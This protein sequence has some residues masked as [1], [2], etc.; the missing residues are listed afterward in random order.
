MPHAIHLFLEQVSH[1]L[2]DN[3]WFY[4]NGPHVLQAG[5]QA[6]EDE[7]DRLHDLM[8]D[9][10]ERELAV[11]PFR[12]KNLESL[13]FPEYSNEYQHIP[14]TLGFTGRPGGPDFYI[15]KVNNS[16]SHGPGGQ[17]HHSIAEFADAC[18]ARVYSGF[19]TLDAIFRSPIITDDPQYKY[20]FEDPVH[21]IK[22]T[23]LSGPPIRS[24]HDMFM[25]QL[26]QEQIEREL[27]LQ[28][29]RQ[30]QSQQQSQQQQQFSQQKQQLFNQQQQ[31]TSSNTLPLTTTGQ[32]QI[33]GMGGIT[34]NA[35]LQAE[36][37]G[38][39]DHVEGHHV[40]GHHKP[41]RHITMPNHMVDI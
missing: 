23:I 29:E 35:N 40:E 21:I 27:Q 36:A 14:W 37:I 39:A 20:F 32:Q 3:A 18:F 10:D 24:Q 8:E 11:R 33:N 12:E 25:L 28:K 34:N 5:P 2:W 16:E 7:I 26:S 6:D 19:D 13:S 38:R 31:Q 4:I 9:Y 1:K 41:K 17:Q 30:Q 22:T 15:N